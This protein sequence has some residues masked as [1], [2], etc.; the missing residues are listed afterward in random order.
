MAA[1]A[2]EL[3]LSHI[4]SL[5][6]FL[7]KIHAD[8]CKASQLDLKEKRAET[9]AEKLLKQAMAFASKGDYKSL[10]A[11]L[12]KLHLYAWHRYYKITSLLNTDKKM[13]KDAKA[14][15][16]VIR[17]IIM[18]EKLAKRGAIES[19]PNM[20]R[21]LN[22]IKTN[23][24]SNLRGVYSVESINTM[25]AK[26]LNLYN[27]VIAFVRLLFF[28]RQNLHAQAES[29]KDTIELLNSDVVT[30]KNVAF[31]LREYKGKIAAEKQS[32]KGLDI[33]LEAFDDA[34]DPLWN[35]AKGRR[36]GRAE[37][38]SRLSSHPRHGEMYVNS[39]PSR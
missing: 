7:K 28:L 6:K 13:Y 38:P 23:V 2:K 3:E 4:G 35:L 18:D 37:P 30:K 12:K 33:E 24:N 9:K 1:T 10:G 8:I 36:S 5:L 11:I 31:D 34:Y 27:H 26:G 29:L 32:L 21:Q 22:V 17:E 15:I 20:L 25:K 14:L 16:Q 19:S 39:L